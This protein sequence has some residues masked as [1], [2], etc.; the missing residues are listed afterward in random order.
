M[1]GVGLA[2]ILGA[3]VVAGC[4][5]ADNE[6]AAGARAGSCERALATFHDGSVPARREV[7]VPPPPQ[8]R[9]VAVTKRTTRI[10]WSLAQL[11]D[12]C[13]PVA[14]KFTV[15]ATTDPGAT[16]T[17]KEIRVRA[18]SGR[19]Q[20]TYPEFLDVPD[21]ANASVYS[22]QGHRSRV[23]EVAIERR[24]DLPPDPPKPPPPVTAPAGEPIACAGAPTSVD[25]PNGDVLVYEPGSR[26]AQLERLTPELAAIDIVRASVQLDGL[27]VCAT[28][29]LARPAGGADFKAQLTLRDAAQARCC[30][31]LLFRRTAGRLELGYDAWTTNG[32]ELR[33]VRDAGARLEGKTLVLSG[34]FPPPNAWQL[35]SKRVPAAETVG[36][37]LTTSYAP[38][39]YCPCYADWL[40]ALAAVREPIVRH[41]DG[42]IVRPGA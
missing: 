15:R 16:P 27:T 24:P 35:G 7:I 42:A 10:E 37:S 41:R 26:P 8:I 23:V 3:V 6:L 40:P 12:A 29:E 28:I 18:L 2:T 25:D 21:V 5:E 19:T 33:P 34:T 11:P 32:H 31:S 1:K 30:A 4:G 36:W 22:R 39:A 38:K 20:I 13:R 9:A 17:S 14:M